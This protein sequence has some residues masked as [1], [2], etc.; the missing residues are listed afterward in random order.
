MQ[1]VV[2]LLIS[3]SISIASYAQKI[4]VQGRITDDQGRPLA[5][6]LVIDKD[7]HT[8]LGASDDDGN[9]TAL[10]LGNQTL[11]FESIGCEPKDVKI[12]R[13][14]II[15]VELKISAIELQE[16]EVVSKILSRII[17]EPTDIEVKG[18]YFHLRTRVRV[19]E[20]MAGSNTRM[21][22]QPFI[23]DVTDGEKRTLRPMVLDGREYAITQKRMYEYDATRDSLTKYR[24]APKA[25]DLENLLPYHDSIFVQDQTHDY[26]AEVLISLEDYRKA[27]YR[28]SFV[29]ANGTVNPLRFYEY[30]L[31]DAQDLG[32][33]YLPQPALQL[34]N[35]KGQVELDFAP[36]MQK[37]DLNHAKN[38]S[39]VERLRN[40]IRSIMNDPNAD[41]KSFAIS[42]MASPDGVYVRNLA[43]AKSRMNNAAEVILS[44]L[45]ADVRQHLDIKTD[46]SVANWAQVEAMLRADSLTDLADKVLEVQK[47]SPKSIDLQ[48]RRM[49]QLKGYN[50]ISQEYLPRFRN[51]YYEFTYSLFRVL[52][53]DEIRDLYA[54]DRKGLTRYEYYQLYKH[55]DT[56]EEGMRYLTE[57]LE[58]YPKFMYAAHVIAKQ[59]LEQGEPNIEILLPFL[60]EDTPHEVLMTQALALLADKRYAA[61]SGIID[62]LPDNASTRE[63]KAVIDIFNGNYALGYEME[64]NTGS[65]N[66]VLLLLAMKRNEEAFD[67]ALALPSGVAKHEYVKA[68][69]ANRLDKVG[70]ALLFLDAAFALDPSLEELATVDG[71]VKDLIE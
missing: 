53:I 69:A 50:I 70:E 59:Q 32:D 12:N 16:V 15:N 45:P 68:V 33:E 48:G 24:Y 39:E 13:R 54:A 55:A 17:P 19:P 25:G 56:P 7:T 64:A 51:V 43:L 49:R 27:Y 14:Q 47:K 22:F 41:L 36:N 61:A 4:R 63:V 10:V 6:A 46:A 11:A 67:K 42:G 37:V 28:D 29:I 18:N 34:R 9:Y 35:D 1:R 8:V 44:E 20:R 30:K 3:L 62:L 58:M 21:I 71:D 31:T 38:R 52:N 66:E 26:R 65:L 40:R 23:A 57:A 60:D 2:F 5:G